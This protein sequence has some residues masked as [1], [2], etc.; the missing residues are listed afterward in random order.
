M[1]KYTSFNVRAVGKAVGKLPSVSEKSKRGKKH[2]N[3]IGDTTISPKGSLYTIIRGCGRIIKIKVGKNGVQNLRGVL[4]A[5]QY[6]RVSDDIRSKTVKYSRPFCPMEQYAVI[7]LIGRGQCPVYMAIHVSTFHLVAI[8]V[9]L[10]YKSEQGVENAS[11]EIK[12]LYTNSC[13]LGFKGKRTIPNCVKF[14]DAFIE[15]SHLKLVLEYMDGGSLS[16]TIFRRGEM[17]DAQLQWVAYR[18]TQCLKSLHQRQ[19]LHRDI[20]PGNVLVSKGDVYLSDFSHVYLSD[21]GTATSVPEYSKRK[22]IIRGKG[23]IQFMC[24]MSLHGGLPADDFCYASDIWS[25]GMT[26]YC[27]AVRQ[28]VPHMDARGA[29]PIYEKLSGRGFHKELNKLRNRPKLHDFLQ[30]CL[31]PDP[32]ARLT[33]SQLLEHEFLRHAKPARVCRASNEKKLKDLRDI[34]MALHQYY[35]PQVEDVHPNAHDSNLETTI[36]NGVVGTRA[37]RQQRRTT[38]KLAPLKNKKDIKNDTVNPLDSRT[39]SK[40]R[41]PPMMNGAPSRRVLPTY[42]RPKVAPTKGAVAFLA[43]QLDLPA[44]TVRATLIEAMP[45]I[46]NE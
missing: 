41:L 7:K 33:A 35:S 27:L 18:I 15:E 25:L 37:P 24:K 2:K 20:K 26:I 9:I 4:R 14:F 34:V 36:D 43:S 22:E 45:W 38:T 39:Q 19:I 44:K 30:K 42:E 23:T 13:A 29:I 10:R 11:N 31:D 8:K 3:A 12:V 5:E 16:D 6:S 32:K 46:S 21:F 1:Q 17:T 28:S 40:P